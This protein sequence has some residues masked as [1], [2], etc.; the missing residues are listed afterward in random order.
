MCALERKMSLSATVQAFLA[1][2]HLNY[3]LANSYASENDPAHQASPSAMA[4]LIL[5]EDG[6][7][8]A[9]ILIPRA[10]LLDLTALNS[11]HGRTWRACAE[12]PI[13]QDKD[14]PPNQPALPLLPDA[15]LLVDRYLLKL[16]PIYLESGTPHIYIKLSQKEFA[17]LISHAHVE[18]LCQPLKPLIKIS[19][20]EENDTS[21]VNQAIQSFSARRIKSRLNETLEIPP[22]PTTVEK[23][24]QLRINPDAH[25]E[26]LVEAVSMDPSLAAQ[27]VSWAASP[28]YAIP[29]KIR[30]IED[31][32]IRVLGFELVVNLAIG[33]AIGKTL[34]L[35][36]DHPYNQPPHWQ[37]AIITATAMERLSRLHPSRN[38]P[39]RGLAYLSGL[40]NN[41]GYLVLGHTFPPHFSLLC[42]HIEANP[43][44]PS[45]YVDQHLFGITRDQIS[46]LLFQSWSLPE[47]VIRAVRWQQ[48]PGYQG[49][50]AN[51]A[52]LLCLCHFLINEAQNTN[53]NCIMTANQINQLYERLGIQANEAHAVVADVL[54]KK[55]EFSA[56]TN[57]FK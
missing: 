20:A 40:L 3:D 29:G 30:S 42:R 46:S 8:K 44:V 2:E 48:V 49:P 4:T 34:Q 38:R 35:P 37:Q 15:L 47:E 43:H 24:I 28:F 26:Q 55:E 25:V 50:Y 57:L 45:A 22:L 52:N 16:D 33:L 6:L 17:R 23:V 41:F 13:P 11:S 5:L 56:F 18:A 39:A 19:L 14:A 7:G 1:A 9:Q 32:I 54:A 21:S 51:Y 10:S 27:I 31:A 36:Q 12:H 53:H